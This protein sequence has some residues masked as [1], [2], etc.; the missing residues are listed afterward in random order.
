MHIIM[1]ETR[2]SREA[3]MKVDIYLFDE[4]YGNVNGQKTIEL[5]HEHGRI[6]SCI[7]VKMGRHPTGVNTPMNDGLAAME[8]MT[9]QEIAGEY[10]KETGT[11]ILEMK[12]GKYEPIQDCDVLK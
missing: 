4:I 11:V 3:R 6:E 9:P 5:L 2:R 12:D 8:G 10:E 1:V 7:G